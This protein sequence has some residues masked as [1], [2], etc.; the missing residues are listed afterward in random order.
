MYDPCICAPFNVTAEDA[1]QTHHLLD[2]AT[3]A[4]LSL[5]MRH[6]SFIMFTG[7]AASPCFRGV[8]SVDKNWDGLTLWCR[9]CCLQQRSVSSGLVSRPCVAARHVCGWPDVIVTLWS[10]VCVCSATPPVP[11]RASH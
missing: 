7:L 2:P 3:I 5:G 8:L 9:K 10:G 1:A 6:A 4:V 11:L